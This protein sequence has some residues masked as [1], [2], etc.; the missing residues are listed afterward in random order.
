MEFRFPL[1]DALVFPIGILRDLRGFF[2]MDVGTAWFSGGDFAHP[3]LGF[4]L[5]GSNNGVLD[6]NSVVIDSATGGFIRR[7]YD[8][9]DSENDE[10][11]DGRGSY[12]FGFNVFLGPFQLTW[13]FARQLDNTVEV[14]ETAGAVLGCDIIRIEDPFQEDGTVS[15]F[16]I[17][18]DF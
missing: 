3:V 12:G 8:F 17:A 13:S 16:Y 1:V 14:C 2:F 5:T 6:P 4:E 9:W 7:K 18:T 15:Q 10:L 11:G